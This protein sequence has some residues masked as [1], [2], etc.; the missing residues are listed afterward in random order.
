MTNKHDIKNIIQLNKTC[1]YNLCSSESELCQY[2]NDILDIFNTIIF[3]DVLKRID[4]L[5]DILID[6]I[7][8]KTLF[9]N[10]SDKLLLNDI[11]LGFRSLFSFDNLYLFYPCVVDYI[12]YDEIS[13]INKNNILNKINNI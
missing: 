9:S 2:Q 13:D 8:L 3:E 7:F 4:I 12:K 5:Y 1:K 6:D 11:H 10:M